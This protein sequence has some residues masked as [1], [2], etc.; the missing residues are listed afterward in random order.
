MNDLQSQVTNIGF[1]VADSAQKGWQNISTFFNKKLSAYNDPN[2]GNS[3]TSYSNGY[4]NFS[5]S[6]QN[7]DNSSG[8]MPRSQ[9]TGSFRPQQNK[10]DDSWGNW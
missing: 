7:S 2:D 5:N 1:R 8:Q 9:T 10:P 6:Y 4:E 3:S